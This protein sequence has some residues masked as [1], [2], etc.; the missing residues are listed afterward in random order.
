MRH[1]TRTIPTLAAVLMLPTAACAGT[2]SRTELP[3]VQA[4]L[5]SAFAGRTC[6]FESDSIRC[7]S[8]DG[9]EE[10]SG[11]TR[12]WPAQFADARFPCGATAAGVVCLMPPDGWGE[13]QTAGPE[14]ELRQHEG[15]PL[16][17]AGD[18][19]AIA[20]GW[21]VGS[22]VH[23]AS[24][25]GLLDAMSSGFVVVALT[26]HGLGAF[27]IRDGL[28][29]WRA[30]PD[31]PGARR[32]L[33]LA[34]PERLTPLAWSPDATRM[35]WFR[36]G[37]ESAPVQ[38]DSPRPVATVA[39]YGASP[40]FCALDVDGGVVC[41]NDWPLRC[42]EFG[43]GSDDGVLRSVALEGPA[44]AISVGSDHACAVVA[45]T[46]YCW[47][48]VSGGICTPSPVVVSELPTSPSVRSTSE[49]KQE[50]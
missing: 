13:L 2:H 17:I 23:R 45:A 27:S 3:V 44:T 22:A 32:L 24:V 7:V 43:E 9:P 21:R 12:V 47:G 25:P 39:G 8:D 5:V 48:R 14:Y 16:F 10:I 1:M 29:S 31:A 30:L 42:I 11:I 18:R 19:V 46:V 33:A 37:I 49:L 35:D 41:A 50:H 38:I 36:D 4:P 26:D 6:V 34:T 20:E 28:A 15:M 40:A